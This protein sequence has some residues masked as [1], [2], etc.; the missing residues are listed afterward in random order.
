MRRCSEEG[1]PDDPGE[2]VREEPLG[3]PQEERSL[4]TQKLWKRASVMT[5]SR[6]PLGTGSGERGD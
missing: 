4:S 5:P 1:Q 2:Q 3:V 6:E